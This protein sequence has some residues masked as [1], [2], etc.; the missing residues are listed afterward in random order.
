MMAEVTRPRMTAREFFELPE[1]TQPTQLLDGEVLVS[2]TPVP[3]HQRLSGRLFRLV[4]DIVPHGVVFYSPID[5]Y[6]DEANVPQPDIVWVAEGSRCRVTDK[7]LEGPPDL[8]IEIL[9]PGTARVDKIRKFRLYERFGVREYWIAD[10]LEAYIEVY[11]L[12]DGQFRLH[13]IF[14]PEDTFTSPLLGKEITVAPLFA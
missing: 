4:E 14:G 7:R 9:S 1:T 6:L 12:V 10:P 2:P 3:K 8:V 11:T 5:V 13:G